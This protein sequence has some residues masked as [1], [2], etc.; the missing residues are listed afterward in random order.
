MG[1]RR[2]R[3]EASIEKLLEQA[4]PNSEMARKRNEAE[5]QRLARTDVDGIW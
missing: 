2:A 5:D 3:R 1:V 4:N